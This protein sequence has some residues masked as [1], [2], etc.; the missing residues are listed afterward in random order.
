MRTSIIVVVAIL[1]MTLLCGGIGCA[2]LS[3]LVTPATI[4][5]GAVRYVA[6]AG[7]ADANEYDG[8]GNL[9]KAEKLKGDVDMAHGVVQL[10]LKQQMEKDNLT[11][12]DLSDAVSINYSAAEAREERLFGTNGLLTLG[13]G[14]AGFGSLTGLIGLM[15][16]R[17]GDVTSA[18]LETAVATATGDAS[19]E[20]TEK[21][22]QVVQLV[23]GIA[24]YMGTLKDAPVSLES[25]KTILN[26]TQDTAT[27][28][29]VKTVKTELNL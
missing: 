15:R 21:Q 5:K 23:Q 9:A 3:D 16:K 25:L 27:Q 1:G 29:A 10:D 4:D 18:E 28:V 22:T 8:Y 13:L 7:V 2:A 14:M 26:M 20:L 6:G 12:A 24:K 19:A 11:Y 17:P